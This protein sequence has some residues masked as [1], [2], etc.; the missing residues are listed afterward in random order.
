MN[1]SSLRPPKLEEHWATHKVWT[2]LRIRDLGANPNLDP[3]FLL[4]FS[5]FL[6]LGS[7]NSHVWCQSKPTIFYLLNF[8]TFLSMW[9]RFHPSFGCAIH[10]SSN[11]FSSILTSWPIRVNE[12]NWIFKN[13]KI[14]KHL[15]HE[16]ILSCHQTNIF[17][18]IEI[19]FLI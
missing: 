15:N 10:H 7:K 4:L 11:I 12:C 3:P 19:S 18:S 13:F 1:P 14:K 6:N 8:S 2:S 9:M 16:H 5:K 17:P